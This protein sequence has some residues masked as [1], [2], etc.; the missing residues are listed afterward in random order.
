MHDK[1]V[2]HFQPLPSNLR[3]LRLLEVQFLTGKSRSTIYREMRSGK[4]APLSRGAP[5][6]RAIGSRIARP[7]HGRE[8]KNEL[9][10]YQSKDVRSRA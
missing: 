7:M 8:L 4:L 9:C 1:A 6:G 5:N 2:E 10:S 3:V